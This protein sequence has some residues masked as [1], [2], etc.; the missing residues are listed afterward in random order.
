MATDFPLNDQMREVIEAHTKKP[1]PSV[2]KMPAKAAR[3]GP[4]PATAAMAVAKKRELDTAP[5][6]VGQLDDMKIEAPGG[7][8]P[9]AIWRPW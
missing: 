5:E 2:E 3:M 4:T 6:S 8:L 7:D 9:A 1:V